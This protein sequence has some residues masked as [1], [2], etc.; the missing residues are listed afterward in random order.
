MPEPEEAPRPQAVTV[1]GWVWLILGIL[2]LLRAVV[3]IVLW[4]M[5]QPDM[6]AF[7]D[8]FGGVPRQ[9]QEMLRPLFEHLA[10]LQTGEAIL[11]AAVA[12]VAIQLLR[13]RPWARA[14][15]QAVCWL[16]LAC[17]GA[18]GVFWV[19]LCGSIAAAVPSS[20]MT[21]FGRI[22]LAAGLAVCLAVAAGLTVMIVLLASA[23][24]REAFR[25]NPGR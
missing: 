2:F 18:F 14:G 19:W 22:G 23:R 10:A 1:I 24:V 9:Q 25:R 17:V 8:A 7:L 12:V 3:N 4:K 6:L 5:L 16:V 13:L 20:S 21:A 15:M 11:S